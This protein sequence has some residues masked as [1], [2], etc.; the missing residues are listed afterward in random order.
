MHITKKFKYLFIILIIAT[1]VSTPLFAKLE[2]WEDYHD[3]SL[4][5]VLESNY[6]P[7]WKNKKHLIYISV[8]LFPTRAKVKYL[9]QSRLVSSLRKE[10]IKKWLQSTNKDEKILKIYRNE[11]LFMDGSTEYWIPVQKIWEDPFKKEIKDGDEVFIYVVFCGSRTMN[12][13]TDHLFLVCEF[14]PVS[15]VCFSSKVD[16]NTDNRDATK[17]Q[18]YRKNIIGKWAEGDSPYGIAS[19][20]EGGIYKAWLYDSP[21][22]EKL[23]LSMVGNWWIDDGHLYTTLNE[24]NPQIEELMKEFMDK[25]VV[26]IIVDITSNEMLLIDEEGKQYIKTKIK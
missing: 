23:I 6:H 19:F 14:E 21:K 16:N 22:K 5:K 25:T 17:D 15:N 9:G 26:D 2:G 4:G 11:Y 1:T 13:V 3:R 20:E 24:M 7:D 8:D 12:K 10:L 18:L